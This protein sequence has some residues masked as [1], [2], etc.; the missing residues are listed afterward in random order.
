MS[1]L[2]SCVAI[3]LL[4]LLLIVIALYIRQKAENR[5]LLSQKKRSEVSLGFI[6]EKLA[7]FLSNFDSQYDPSN[8]LFVGKPIDYIHFGK[9]IITFIEIKSGRSRLSKGQKR[10]KTMIRN[11]QI[12]WYEFRISGE[13]GGVPVNDSAPIV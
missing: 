3:L 11:K 9:D 5:K 4:I 13:A 2:F 6:S 8:L 7:P 1:I 12:G 10:I